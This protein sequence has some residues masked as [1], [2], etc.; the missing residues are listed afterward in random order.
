M[1]CRL[2]LYMYIGDP[3]CS[4]I[5]PLEVGKTTTEKASTGA[6]RTINS[7]MFNMAL[8]RNNAT[9][10]G[11]VRTQ[12]NRSDCTGAAR[13]NIEPPCSNTSL[14]RNIPSK[15]DSCGRLK[16]LALHP[17]SK[18]VFGRCRSLTPISLLT[19]MLFPLK[20]SFISLVMHP[21][22]VKI[23]FDDDTPKMNRNRSDKRQ[24]C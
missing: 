20:E 6:A 24:T 13:T 17:S 4:R 11:F 8:V 2:P 15:T 23:W 9:W 10:H 12:T 21:S 3:R 5:S 22:C 7:T 18:N 16:L 19:F 1:C 14:V